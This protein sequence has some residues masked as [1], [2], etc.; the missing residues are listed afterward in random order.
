METEHFK[1]GYELGK[2]RVSIYV[3]GEEFFSAI[4]YCSSVNHISGTAA[5]KAIKEFEA[6]YLKGAA[7]E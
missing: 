7:G 5:V 4:D 2:T 6:G 1:A 3:N